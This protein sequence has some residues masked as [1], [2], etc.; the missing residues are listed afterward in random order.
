MKRTQV[1]R[2]RSSMKWR[3][4][5]WPPSNRGGPECKPTIGYF[6]PNDSFHCEIHTHNHV[7]MMHLFTILYEWTMKVLLIA[8]HKRTSNIAVSYAKANQRT[9]LPMTST[10]SPLNSKLFFLPLYPINL[11]NTQQ[12]RALYLWSNRIDN[13]NDS[14]KHRVY[15]NGEWWICCFSWR[16]C[17]E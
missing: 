6:Y 16:H 17:F 10:C 14:A 15:L 9:F 5:C 2:F 12:R 11:V 13:V 4:V 3:I 1:W 8:A 7:H